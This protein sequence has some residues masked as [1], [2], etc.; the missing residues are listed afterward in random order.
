VLFLFLAART[1]L[2]PH[3]AGGRANGADSVFFVAFPSSW[4]F[5]PALG[6]PTAPNNPSAVSERWA[7]ALAAKVPMSLA[8][9]PI[10]VAV[11]I[12]EWSALQTP[13]V[14][15]DNNTRKAFVPGKFGLPSPV[16]RKGKPPLTEREQIVLEFKKYHTLNRQKMRLL[17]DRILASRRFEKELEEAWAGEDGPARVMALFAEREER[18]DARRRSRQSFTPEDEADPS[19]EKA[20]GLERS[21]SAPASAARANISAAFEQLY[22]LRS[23]I[24]STS[25]SD[26]SE[27]AAAEAEL[28]AVKADID[29]LLADLPEAEAAEKRQQTLEAEHKFRINGAQEAE[30]RA[31]ADRQ[32]TLTLERE[33]EELRRLA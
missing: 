33:A 6:K 13:R 12:A 5:H 30:R 1:T 25:P 15:A 9:R 26:A 23:I 24:Q 16:L 3:A 19:S 28:V 11:K 8:P 29:F 20:L 32:R 18:R 22:A 7:K 4:R 14:S 21:S 31:L 10:R 17:P 27:L 2:C